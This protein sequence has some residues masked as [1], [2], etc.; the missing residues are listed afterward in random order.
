MQCNVSRD[1]G[2]NLNALYKWKKHTTAEKKTVTN[3]FGLVVRPFLSF[4]QALQCFWAI[5]SNF[6]LHFTFVYLKKLNSSKI[7]GFLLLLVLSLHMYV[8][9][10]FNIGF[11]TNTQTM[12][13]KWLRKMRSITKHFL[14]LTFWLI[15]NTWSNRL[16][17]LIKTFWTWLISLRLELKIS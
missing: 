14:N 1:N 15:A 16:I 10:L 12:I 11:Q 4:F 7:H 8:F 9:N 13:T 6:H 2:Y 5:F 3:L 17:F